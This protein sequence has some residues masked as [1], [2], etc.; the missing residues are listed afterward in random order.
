MDR[1]IAGMKSA[2]DRT[3]RNIP[4]LIHRGGK[5]GQGGKP[6]PGQRFW[7]TAD[8]EA[9]GDQRFVDDREGNAPRMGKTVGRTA[10]SGRFSTARRNP[11]VPKRG[12]GR[13]VPRW[14]IIP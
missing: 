7:R 2:L 12:I 14:L 4:A 5:R 10:L 11:G 1:G 6:L 8:A 13:S 9:S 3:P